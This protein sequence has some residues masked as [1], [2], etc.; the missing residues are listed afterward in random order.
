MQSEV[1]ELQSRITRARW[2]TAKHG[3]TLAE[4]C[5]SIPRSTDLSCS[6][7][8]SNARFDRCLRRPFGQ[9]KPMNFGEAGIHRMFRLNEHS[10]REDVGCASRLDFRGERSGLCSPAKETPARGENCGL[11]WCP[12]VP[13][14]P[15]GAFIRKPAGFPSLSCEDTGVFTSYKHDIPSTPVPAGRGFR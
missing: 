14:A 15:S 11:S 4:Y 5:F 7:A 12:P 1:I 13:P 8:S 2:R 6:A 3:A 10:P 9:S